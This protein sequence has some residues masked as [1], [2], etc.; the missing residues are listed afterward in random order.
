MSYSTHGTPCTMDSSSL[1]QSL[2]SM[3]ACAQRFNNVTRC[4]NCIDTSPLLWPITCKVLRLSSI[5]YV[6]YAGTYIHTNIHRAYEHL[7]TL[8]IVKRKA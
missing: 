6:L 5:S 1:G 3:I 2:R 4:V 8:T 7:I